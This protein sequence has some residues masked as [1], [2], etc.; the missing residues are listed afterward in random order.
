MLDV[1]NIF[2]T[3]GLEWQL[4]TSGNQI[5]S[6]FM[7]FFRHYSTMD[8]S[9]WLHIDIKSW[10]ANNHLVPNPTKVE[11]MW[12]STPIRKHLINQAAFIL[13]SIAIAPTIVTL[14]LGILLDETLSF[15][16]LINH[17]TQIWYYQLH[18][19]KAIHCYITTTAT[20]QLKCAFLLSQIGTNEDNYFWT[21][22]LA[23][24]CTL[25]KL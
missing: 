20:I 5:H 11:F 10:M 7:S 19:I 4:Y 15:H 12:L 8:Q 25:S 3:F 6:F 2:K 9:Y 22:K 24:N 16:C 17:L 1:G 13:D 21:T 14:L 23:L 18:R